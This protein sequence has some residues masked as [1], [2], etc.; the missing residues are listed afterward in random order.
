MSKI[1]AYITILVI[2]SNGCLCQDE[3]L[4]DRKDVQ[5]LP[6]DFFLNTSTDVYQFTT[7]LNAGL[8]GVLSGLPNQKPCID[9]IYDA[10]FVNNVFN[11]YN[12]IKGIRKNSNF[13]NIFNDISRIIINMV[14]KTFN[15]VNNCGPYLQQLQGRIGQLATYMQ[16]PN[17][18]DQVANFCMLNLQEILMKIQV[19][20][21]NVVAKYFFQAGIS[22]GELI[23]YVFFTNFTPSL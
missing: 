2:L 6:A 14:P 21:S 9:G 10:Q 8:G 4:S 15:V 18:L 16:T 19:F 13:F 7:G 1:V 22:A 3:F 11:L 5:A 23:N 20:V 12:I 17:Y